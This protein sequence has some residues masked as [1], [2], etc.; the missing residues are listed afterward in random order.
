MLEA[1][2]VIAGDLGLDV[3]LTTGRSRASSRGKAIFP[4][5]GQDP[6]WHGRPEI[7]VCGKAVRNNGKCVD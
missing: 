5:Q 6:A 3:R 2:T 4:D 7:S 1:S